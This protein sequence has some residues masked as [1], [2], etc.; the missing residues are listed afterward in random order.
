MKLN[1]TPRLAFLAGF[2]IAGGL[3]AFAL[4]LQ[5]VEYQD[6]CPLCILQRVVYIALAAVFLIA[7]LHAPRRTGV[8]I[9]SSLLVMIATIGAGIAGRHVWL[10]H[11]P[12]DKVPECGPGLSYMLDRL[13]LFTAFEKIFRGSGECAEVGWR[14][15]G[16]SIAE[17]SLVWFVLL[18]AYAIYIA[19]AARR[20][21][22]G[23]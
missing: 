8:F 3:I 13:P 18:G 9:Y 17:W 5:Y 21:A 16:L 6:P 10:Q 20:T 11:L 22:G 4:Y 12:K 15:M 2:F 7:G 19:I 23:V 14:M 1:L